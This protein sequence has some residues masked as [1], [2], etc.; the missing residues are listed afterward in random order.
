[1]ARE[2]EAL[3]DTLR[4]ESLD[5]IVGNTV[6]KKMCHRIIER[7]SHESIL[8]YGPIGT[9]KTCLASIVAKELLPEWGLANHVHHINSS[10]DAATLDAVREMIEKDS[11]LIGTRIKIFDEAHALSPKVQELLLTEI[12]SNTSGNAYFFCTSNHS[13]LSPAL[14]DRCTKIEL[15]LL[16]PEEARE[17]IERVWRWLKF[18]D[19]PPN[20]FI[21]EAQRLKLGSPRQIINALAEYHDGKPANDA[22]RDA[23]GMTTEAPTRR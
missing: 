2:S 12:D 17:L 22:V 18:G 8:F 10:S 15:K 20:D 9:G 4:P 5:G 1:M 11:H 6:A 16:S 13:K 14:R 19:D 3:R 21:A 7:K 23:L